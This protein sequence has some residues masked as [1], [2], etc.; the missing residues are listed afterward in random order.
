MT[1]QL[2]RL[3]P[4][5]ADT[6]TKPG[7]HADGGNLYLS[8]GK[9]GRRRSWSF[10]FY[11]AGKRHQKGLGA[12]GKGRVTLKEAREKGAEMRKALKA[13]ID[14]LRAKPAAVAAP[15]FG[16]A[17]VDYIATHKSSWTSPKH[18][19]Q[20]ERTVALYCDRIA[21][22][23]VDQIDTEAVLRVLTPLWARVPETASRL[24]ARIE[25]VR[26]PPAPSAT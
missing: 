16:E 22:T 26:T 21:K 24:R 1:R 11:V 14:P 25:L 19:Q 9:D 3:P 13:G 8:I 6:I 4:N 7:D 23:P 18:L 2:N 17:A 10:I 5:A 12:A 15:T 20:W